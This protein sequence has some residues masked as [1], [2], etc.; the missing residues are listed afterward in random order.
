MQ[1]NSAI[2]GNVDL[3]PRQYSTQDDQQFAQAGKLLRDNRLDL[4]TADGAKRSLE[5]M[6]EWFQAHRSVPVSV[7]SI[8]RAVEERKQEFT[9]LTPAQHAWYSAAEANPQLANDLATYVAGTSGRPGSF[10]KDGDPLFE[11]LLE[12]FKELQSRREPVSA[13]SIAHA[14]NRIANRPGP[15]LRYVSEPRR[16]E[17]VSRAA[18][19]DNGEPFLG[20]DLVPDGRGGLRSKTHAEQKRD[21]EA[22]EEAA[23]AKTSV[24]QRLSEDEARWKAMCEEACRFG[25]HGQQ[26]AIKQVYDQATGSY[27]ERFKA[28]N[29]VV[30]MYQRSGAI[31]G[32]G[33]R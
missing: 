14:E 12:I 17:P 15:K 21:R 2:L 11:N 6:D 29:R 27:A 3:I 10:I 23:A 33:G 18:K 9:W 16:T 26:A 19:E 24:Q 1:L 30:Q 25:S 22:A 31:S 8:F 5:L 32:W 7:E 28:V 13:Q 4:F 20:A